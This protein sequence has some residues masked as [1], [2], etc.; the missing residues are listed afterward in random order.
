MTLIRSNPVYKV[1]RA[2]YFFTTYNFLEKSLEEVE[3]IFRRIDLMCNAINEK[4]GRNIDAEEIYLMVISAINDYNPQHLAAIDLDELYFEMEALVMRYPPVLFDPDA[5]EV[6][7]TLKSTYGSS[8]SLLSNTG[9]IKGKTLRKVLQKLELE[10][11]FDFQLYSDE[12]G[13]SKPNQQ[14]FQLMLEK[15]QS[16]KTDIKLYEIIHVGDN[17]IAD[18]FGAK[19]TGIS[20]LV[21]NSNSLTIKSLISS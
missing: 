16:L 18:D 6:L 13:L 1:E 11:L 2:K 21:I 17:L 19:Q 8:L 12:A 10:E 5:V 4:T 9:F 20:S 15:V 14:F 3:L 7:Q